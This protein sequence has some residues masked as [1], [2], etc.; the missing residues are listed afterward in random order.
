MK[1]IE[2]Q[3]IQYIGI[4]RLPSSSVDELMFT[5]H[6][7]RQRYVIGSFELL[8]LINYNLI[9]VHACLQSLGLKTASYDACHYD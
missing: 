7:M 8:D 2:F 6:V 3:G 1:P 5:A 4:H 9:D